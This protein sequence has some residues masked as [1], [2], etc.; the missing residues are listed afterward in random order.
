M[1]SLLPEKFIKS[2][3]GLLMISAF[4]IGCSSGS[5]APADSDGDGVADAIDAVPNDATQSFDD[6]GDGGSGAAAAGSMLRICIID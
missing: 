2:L 1:K 5:D 4:V 3:I 6:D